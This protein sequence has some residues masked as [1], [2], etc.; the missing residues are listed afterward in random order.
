MKV[1]GIMGWSA[2]GK[3][4]LIER[5]IPLFVARGLR[6]STVKH[7]HHEVDLDS[8]GKDSWRHRNAGAE[9][10]ILASRQRLALMREH[11]GA[12]PPLTEVLARLAPVDLV[13]VEGYK[14]DTH[15]KVELWRAAVG[16]PPLQPGDPT[17]RAFAT[18]GAA[19]PGI[20][21]PVLDLNDPGTIAAFIARDLGLD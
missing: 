6:V 21:V 10:V 18:D 8:P 17:V 12:E 11:R 13:L 20:T 3:T 9:E 15:P 7:V 16:Q 1:Y 2:S 14:R 5:L 19:P 4:T